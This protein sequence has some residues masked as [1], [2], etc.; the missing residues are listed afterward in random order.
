MST[1]SVITAREHEVEILV[2]GRPVKVM[3]PKAT[4]L[5][6]KEAAINQGVPIGLEFLLYEERPGKNKQVGDN[7]P[8]HVE[9]HSRFLAIANDD[10]S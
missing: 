3:G 9:H 5:E 6:I 2:N 10:N 7:E 4:G 1:E 8:V